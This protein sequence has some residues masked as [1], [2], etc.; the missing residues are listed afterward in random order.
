MIEEWDDNF[1]FLNLNI[2]H[3]PKKVCIISLDEIN[4]DWLRKA[5]CV[6]HHST[7]QVDCN[8]NTQ[9]C[10]IFINVLVKVAI[11][12]VLVS[13]H[14]EL[15]VFVPHSCPT[16]E[17]EVFP[18]FLINYWMWSVCVHTMDL[19]E[20]GPNGPTRNSVPPVIFAK[21]IKHLRFLLLCCGQYCSIS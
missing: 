4:G 5:L 2:R 13:T 17:N 8:L 16:K 19:P 15:T 21:T 1:K 12:C 3:V 7:T 6:E 20:A 9:F 11:S 18:H 14:N 10:F